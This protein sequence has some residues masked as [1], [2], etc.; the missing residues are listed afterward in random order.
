M[1]VDGDN[2]THDN[3]TKGYKDVDLDRFGTSVLWMSNVTS[4]FDIG[5]GRTSRWEGIWCC[6][7]SGCSHSD[8]FVKVCHWGLGPV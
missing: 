8:W 3:N 1:D 2:T 6:L 5:E 7:F 4:V